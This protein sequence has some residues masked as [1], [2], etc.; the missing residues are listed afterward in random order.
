MRSRRAPFAT[1]TTLLLGTALSLLFLLSGCQPKPAPAPPPPRVGGA[2]SLSGDVVRNTDRARQETSRAFELM[3][4]G[5]DAEAETVLKQALLADPMYGAAR[6]NLGVVYFRLNRLYEAAWE[7]QNAAK[8]MP[9]QAEPQ[10]NLG[11]VMERAGKSDEALRAYAKAVEIEPENV[12][13]SGNLAR[14]RIRL[15]LGDEQTRRLLEMV[16]MK[17]TR[18]EWVDW[19]RFNL[20]RLRSSRAATNAAPTTEPAGSP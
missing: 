13:Y 1:A 6:N 7:F 3:Q 5:K 10:N 8:L 14:A 9:L 2:G 12:E 15:G 19:A 16:V 20:T 4:K 18:P 17:D 11:L